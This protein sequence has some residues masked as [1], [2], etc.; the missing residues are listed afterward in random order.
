MEFKRYGKLVLQASARSFQS[1]F[2]LQEFLNRLGVHFPGCKSFA[3]ASTFMNSHSSPLQSPPRH[4]C[5]NKTF[6]QVRSPRGCEAQIP[7]R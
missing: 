4:W 3:I 5:E 6:G 1:D 7:R 2:G